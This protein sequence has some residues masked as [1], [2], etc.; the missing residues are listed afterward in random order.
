MKKSFVIFTVFLFLL[1]MGNYASG[2]EGME[3][4]DHTATASSFR[5][6][7]ANVALRL[8]PEA[9]QKGTTPKVLVSLSDPMSGSP[10][11]DAELYMKIEK[12]LPMDHACAADAFVTW[13]REWKRWTRFRRDH[14]Y[15]VHDIDGGPFQLQKASV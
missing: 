10:I 5:I 8:D 11:Y 14:G 9:Y 7:G 1:V 15:V 6:D 12:D 4:H 13:K 2:M 3:G